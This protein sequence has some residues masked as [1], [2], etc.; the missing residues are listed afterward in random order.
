MYS[1][2]EEGP[3]VFISHIAVKLVAIVVNIVFISLFESKATTVLVRYSNNV[4]ITCCH[5][6][7]A[8]LTIA[9]NSGE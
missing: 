9:F 5:L 2:S 6:W 3:R 4:I 8:E 7:Q 1:Q